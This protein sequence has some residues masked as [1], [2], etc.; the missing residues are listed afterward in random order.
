MTHREIVWRPRA[1]DLERSHVARLM[2][3]HGI[4]GPAELRRRAAADPHWFYPA[5]IEDLGI[6]FD[7]PWDRLRDDS[8]GLPWTEWFLGGRLNLVHNVLDRHVRDGRGNELAVVAEREGGAPVLLTYAELNERVCRFA[9]ALIRLGVG[10][11]DSIGFYL[12]MTADVVVALLACLKIGAV[13]VPVFGGFGPDAL[14]ARL[15]DA[16]ARVLL[17]ADGTLRRGKVV[18][19]KALA[20]QARAL[21]GCVEHVVVLRNLAGE[22]SRLGSRDVWWHE[23]EVGGDPHEPTVSLDA[24]ARSLVLYTSGTTGRPKGAVHTHAGVQLVTAKEV[25]YHMDVRRGDVLFWVTDIGWMMGPWAIL[26]GLFHGATVVVM[27]GAPD[28]PAADRLWSI[29]E[30]H[31]VTHLGVAPTLVRA[32]AAH[33][34]EAAARHDLSSVRI[35]G[36]TGEPWDDASYR[37]FSDVAGAGRCPIINISGGT[38]LMGCLLAPL[39]VA[40]LKATSLQGPALGMDVDVVDERGASVRGE[41]GYLVCRNAAPNMTRGFLNDPGRYLETYF[42][43]FGDSVWSHGDWAFVDEDGDW[44]LTGRADDTLKIAGK[45]V[46]PGEVEA[47]AIAHSAV[48]EAA[49]VGLPDPVKGIALVVLA[50]TRPGFDGTPALAT[51]VAAHLGAHLGAT[52]RPSRVVWV[53]ALPVTRSGKILRGIIRKVLAGED[54]GSLASVANP[55]AVAALRDLAGRSS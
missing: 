28:H 37:W 33:G 4:A 10:L 39:P 48:R 52:M 6:E 51:E 14:A 19:L 9:S 2:R 5:V 8:R 34:T 41:V 55:E 54:P 25:G 21:A 17:T 16:G 26:G 45:R 32:L 24:S 31:R 3:R 40:P 18:A 44:F 15:A 27:D 22:S 35:L 53:D 1:D 47:A 11:G 42:G 13:P 50:V 43:Q 30:R 46:G 12:P 20:D 29:V 36:S 23:L 49:A 38:E 7:A